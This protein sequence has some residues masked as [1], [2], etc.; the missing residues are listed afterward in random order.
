[1]RIRVIAGG[2][3]L[4]GL[5]AGGA[6]ARAEVFA[7]PD[8]VRQLAAPTEVVHTLQALED[9][10]A[11]G[12]QRYR[13]EVQGTRLVLDVV[14]RFAGGER[15][16]EHAVMDLADGYRALS[17]R[18]V[19]RRGGVVFEDQHA[20]FASGRVR[21]LADGVR[22]ERTFAF[23]PDTY[24]G[25]MLGVVLAA[26]PELPSRTSAFQALVF[27]PAPDVYTLRADVVDEEMFRVGR[28]REPTTKLRLKA[29]LGPVKNA[30]FA[31]LIPTHYFWFTREEPPEFFAFEGTLG[32][33]NL[34]VL[35]VPE[36]A[37]APARA[38]RARLP[39]GALN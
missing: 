3:A 33:Q 17:F 11:V 4:L 12:T 36:G 21:W 38:A 27:R 26:V 15:W 2:V 28:S 16:D 35:M 24:M 25:P 6:S 29:D 30:L 5:L 14:T 31:N 37:L 19:G 1:M 39:H 22:R 32:Y 20:D 8:E 10:R 7:V 9:G 34:T 18:K 13:A 23:T